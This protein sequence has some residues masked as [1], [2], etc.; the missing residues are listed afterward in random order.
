[1]V[2]PQ[3]IGNKFG[4]ELAVTLLNSRG[5]VGVYMYFYTYMHIYIYAL[6]VCSWCNN[7]LH[8]GIGPLLMLHLFYGTRCH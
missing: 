4:D 1:M 6:N 5:M 3:N 7:A 2:S 8:L